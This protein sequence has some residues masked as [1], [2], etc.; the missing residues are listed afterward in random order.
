M[1]TFVIVL[2]V[3]VVWSKSWTPSFALEAS[4]PVSPILSAL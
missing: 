4:L 3:I 2:A 1:A